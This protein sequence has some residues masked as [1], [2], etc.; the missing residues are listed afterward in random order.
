MAYRIKYVANKN[1]VDWLNFS[2]GTNTFGLDASK[3]WPWFAASEVTNLP[4]LVN[5]PQTYHFEGRPGQRLSFAGR[6]ETS[7]AP[8]NNGGSYK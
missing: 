8:S 2:A 3:N 1:I 7:L 5:G 6:A 4:A